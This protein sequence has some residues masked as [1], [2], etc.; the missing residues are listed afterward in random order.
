MT[1]EFI[2]RTLQAQLEAAEGRAAEWEMI[3]NGLEARLIATERTLAEV[4][5]ERYPDQMGVR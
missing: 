5:A 1:P 2:M 3:A 4:I